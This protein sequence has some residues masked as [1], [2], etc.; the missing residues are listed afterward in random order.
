MSNSIVYLLHSSNALIICQ[1]IRRRHDFVEKCASMNGRIRKQLNTCPFLKNF[2][3]FFHAMHEA[4]IVSFVWSSWL[5]NKCSSLDGR[6]K[7][8]LQKLGILFLLV[9]HLS[10]KHEVPILSNIGLS[11]TRNSDH[12]QASKTS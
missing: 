9:R 8:F 3:A 1:N 10:S 11:M 12:V 2:G 5:K 7:K 4:K 6:K